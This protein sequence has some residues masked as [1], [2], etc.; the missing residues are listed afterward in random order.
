V[1]VVVVVVLL[2]LL[3]LLLLVNYFTSQSRT[4]RASRCKLRS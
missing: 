2:L 3:L 1:V 4:F